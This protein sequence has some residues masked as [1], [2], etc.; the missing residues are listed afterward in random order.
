MSNKVSFSHLTTL[1]LP[2]DI[3]DIRNGLFSTCRSLTDIYYSG[4][5][6]YWETKTQDLSLFAFDDLTDTVTVHCADGSLIYRGDGAIID[7]EEGSVDAMLQNPCA[8]GHTFGVGVCTVCGM[9]EGA[10]EIFQM[11]LTEDKKGAVISAI[12]AGHRTLEGELILPNVYFDPYVGIVPVVMVADGVFEGQAK[13]TKVVLPA[14]LT[15]IGSHA[16]A[17]CENLTEI[18]FPETLRSIGEYAFADC[19]SLV[20]ADLPDTVE[21]IGDFAFTNC[22]TITRFAFPPLVIYASYGLLNGCDGLTEIILHEN[23]NGLD[24]SL[25]YCT[26]LT[27]IHIPAKMTGLRVGEFAGCSKLREITVAEDNPQFHSYGNLLI[28]TH[29]KDV[30]AGGCEPEFPTDGSITGIHNEAFKGRNIKKVVI[31]EGVEFVGAESFAGC[32][33]LTEIVLPYSLYQISY[34][35]FAECTALESVTFPYRI[36]LHEKAFADCTSLKEVNLCARVYGMQEGLF[37]GCTNLTIVNYEDTVESF[38]K[39]FPKAEGVFKRQDGDTTVTV[40]CT[41]GELKY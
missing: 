18:N 26:S 33:E 4:S 34:R 9:T 24:L 30:L 25:Q 40:Y 13:L 38:E 29:Q 35:A 7:T 21:K 12:H 17:W 3:R 39:K 37:M 1:Y 36:T 16:F 14:T 31:P 22:D 6:S 11:T 10:Q 5:K 19:A 32:K 20:S 15:H 23:M 41:D 8:K 27:A 28:I 2:E